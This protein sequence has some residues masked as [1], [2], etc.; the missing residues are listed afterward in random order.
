MTELRTTPLH[1]LHLE[2]GAK[3]MPFA[4]WDMPVSFAGTL[5]EHAHTRSSASLFDV[6]HMA[7]VDLDASAAEGLERLVPSAITT[8]GVGRCRYTAFT[9]ED[10]GILDDAIVTNHGDHLGLV[11][12]ASRR[13]V[14]LPHLRDHLGGAAVTERT[15]TAL[16]ALQGP[17]AVAVLADLGAEVGDLFSMEASATEVAGV[18]VWLSRSGYTGEDGGELCVPA[19]R[20][21][22]LARALL[23]DD[24]VLPA[25]L[26]ARDTLRL[27]AGLCLY[28][29]DLDE[30]VS[31]VEAGLSWTI[32]KR[33]RE[34]GGFLGADRVLAELADGPGRLRVGLR[35]EGR[36]PARPP[37]ALRTAEGNEAGVITSGT[38]GPT[39]G[40]PVA[41]A[42][43]DP[44]AATV[45][46]ALVADVR[47]SDVA[48]EVVDLPFVPSGSVRRPR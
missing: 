18:P 3:M 28:G 21:E 32:Q 45:G 9:N 24:R 31:P 13:D 33:R 11:V 7:V 40:A 16:L 36:R 15:N 38:F 4:G 39:V 26:G 43:V 25:G 37:A 19:D 2:S 12:N 35:P 20:A 10:G 41:M 1:E 48:C 17:E 8:L 34:E 27:E 44:G 22:E 47:G 30:T 23:A 14:M 42:Y 5:D 6:S 29:N 46:T